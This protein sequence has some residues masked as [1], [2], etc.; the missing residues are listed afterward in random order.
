VPYKAFRL[1]AV[2]DF[3]LGRADFFSGV[4]RV[5]WGP[6]AQGEEGGE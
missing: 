3:L 4:S 2:Q 6:C 5:R 1:K